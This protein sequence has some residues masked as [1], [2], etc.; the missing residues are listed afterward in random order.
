MEIIE[1]TFNNRK[2]YGYY[3]KNNIFIHH[4]INDEPATIYNNGNKFWY[5]HGLVH[6]DNDKPA[7][8]YRDGSKF[9]YKKG[10]CHRENG[11][12]IIDGNGEKQYYLNGIYYPNIKTDEEWIIKKILE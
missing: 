6:R 12:A 7:Y 11:P 1:R 3:N 2:Q 5:K 4:N 8:E 9:W 10:K